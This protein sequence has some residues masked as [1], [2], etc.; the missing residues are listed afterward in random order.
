MAPA[1]LQDNFF[2]EGALNSG[3]WTLQSGVLSSLAAMHGSQVL[4]ALT[5]TPSGL[6]MSGIR[7]PGQFMGIQ[8]TA[9][10]AAP[11]TFSATVSGL[12]QNGVPFEIYLVSG[13]LQQW[14]S[15]AGHLGG[16]GGPRGGVEVGGGV[17]HLFGEVR[18]P[19]GGSS[20]EHGVW[21]NHTGN[22]QPISALGNKVFEDPIAGLAYTVQINLG[23][24]G[25]AAVTFL[26]AAHLVLAAQSVPV[27]TGPFYVVL[28][29]RDGPTMARLAVGAT[30]AGRAGGGRPGDGAGPGGAGGADDGLFPGA[31][32]ALRQLGDLAGVRPLLAAGGGPGLAALL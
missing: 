22:G 28:A 26:D 25:L 29:G 16:R 32:H 19:L 8:S 17:R 15:V 2:A 24:D 21:I 1:G 14:V 31:T 11:F 7:G 20:P 6:Q 3:W 30:A 23:A 4:P 10:Y 5:F 12:E 27:G 18:I 9:A 13:D